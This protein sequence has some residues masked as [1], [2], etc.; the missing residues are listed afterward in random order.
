LTFFWGAVIVTKKPT[1]V[2]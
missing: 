1:K 2:S